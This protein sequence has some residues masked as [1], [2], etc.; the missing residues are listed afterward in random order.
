[1]A[2][3]CISLACRARVSS[4]RASALHAA[5]RLREAIEGERIELHAQRIEP[6]TASAQG[7]HMEILLRVRAEDGSLVPPG[8][9]VPAAERFN[10]GPRLDRH[11]LDLCLHQLEAHPAA[12]AIAT[13]SINLTGDSVADE[14]FI[15]FAMERLRTSRFP[16]QRLCFEITET[17]AERN[18]GR[19]QRFI[20]QLRELGC[21]VALDD[22]GAGFC[23]FGYLSQLEVDYFKID[24]SFVHDIQHS[25]LSR[26]VAR[27]IT[28]IAHTL[29]KQAIAEHTETEA[30]L[31]CLRELGVDF[32]QGHPFDRPGPVL[33][34]LASMRAS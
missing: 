6:M 17:S 13:C 4:D 11:V 34:L 5:V 18:I 19:A 16:A 10:L 26:A 32:A 30:D 9:I 12:D 27:S 22:F 28:E 24:G 33:Q 23:S 20:G 3:G 7:L 14:S 2:T 8:E 31:A 29:G 1:M 15:A 25:A 21:R